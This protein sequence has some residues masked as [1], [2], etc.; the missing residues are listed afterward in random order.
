MSFET[1]FEFTKEN[2]VFYLKELAKEYRKQGGK[3]MPAELILVGGASILI[4]YGFRDMTNDIDALILAPSVMKDAI[5]CVGDKFGLPN[6]WLNADFKNTDSF[7]QKLPEFSKF[8]KSWSNSLS[9][10]T[11]AAEYLIA[12]KLRS[13]RQ[14]KKDLSDIIGILAEHEKQKKPITAEQIKKAVTDLYGSWEALPQTSQVFLENVLKEEHL[15]TLY[16]E[17]SANEKDT[18]KLLIQFEQDYPGVTKQSNVNA[19]AENLQKKSNSDFLLAQ[20]RKRNS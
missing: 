19:I 15:N 5:N 3:T 13:G 10:R 1:K 18:K 20:L 17:I 4:N 6:N 12:M 7:S 9:V 16:A 8:Y 11:L 2:I 14:Y